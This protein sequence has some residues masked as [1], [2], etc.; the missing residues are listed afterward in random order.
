MNVSLARH[1]ICHV[2]SLT[3]QVEMLR[4]AAPP[5][6]ASVVYLKPLRYLPEG[7]LPGNFVRTAIFPLMPNLS[8]TEKRDR[9]APFM[10]PVIPHGE[11]SLKP[12]SHGN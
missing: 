9:F 10:A 2:L 11:A 12:I 4:V 8:V 7:E 1:G 3:S 6:V 5:V